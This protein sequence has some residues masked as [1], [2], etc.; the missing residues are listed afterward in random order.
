MLH[1]EPLENTFMQI[2]YRLLIVYIGLF[3]ATSA[4]AVTQVNVVGL[5]NGKAV[6]VINNGKP[7]T[8][9]VG[10]S[11]EEGVKLISA[12]SIKVVLE[13]EGKRRELGWGRR[14]PLWGPRALLAA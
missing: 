7:K 2:I 6:L 1:I 9:S 12:D 3:Y 5:F 14:F 4:F 11:S 10:Q 13:I 8:L